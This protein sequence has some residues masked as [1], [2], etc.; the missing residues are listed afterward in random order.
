M[1]RRYD[2]ADAKRRILTACVRFFLEKGYTRTTVAEIVKEA[3]VSISTFQ[4]VFRTKDGVLVELVKFMFG[5]QFDMAGQI[6]G[7]KL[8]PVY[9]YAVETSIQLALTE[10]NE[11][12]RDIY[13][14][15]YSH[16][17]ASEYIY[18]HT[19]SELYRIFGS[20][21]PSYTESDFYE[22]EIGSAGMMRGYMSRPCDK[23]FTLEKK[24]GP[25]PFH[26]FKRLRGARRRAKA[27]AGFYRQ[28]GYPRHCRAGHAGAVQSACHAFFLPAAGF[29][30]SIISQHCPRLSANPS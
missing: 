7:Q 22:L 10:L 27:G 21:L 30:K 12:L 25:L 24:V 15:A 23:Y 6:A 14:E 13:L 11:N 29:R 4:N 20:Y 5:S 28:A 1:P 2:S 16:T 8:P 17:E 18:Q 9:V 26:E 19:S 3:D